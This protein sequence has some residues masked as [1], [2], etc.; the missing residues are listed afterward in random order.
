M[1]AVLCFGLEA[2]VASG[3]GAVSAGVGVADKFN[4]PLARG[5]GGEASVFGQ[6]DAVDGGASLAAFGAALQLEAM[7]SARESL[8][9][10]DA[11][12]GGGVDLDFPRQFFVNKDVEIVVAGVGNVYGDAASGEVGLQVGAH[13]VERYP[14]AFGQCASGVA[15]AGVGGRNLFGEVGAGCLSG[16]RD[17]KE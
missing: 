12:G 3:F 16:G 6:I 9:Q 1:V 8:C 13:P 17:D 5:Y 15:D 11:C 2:L 7:E 10:D 14:I 4:E